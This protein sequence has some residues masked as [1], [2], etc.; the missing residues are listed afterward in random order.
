MTPHQF[1][2]PLFSSGDGPRTPPPLNDSIGQQQ[3]ADCTCLG[4]LTFQCSGRTKANPFQ[5][6]RNSIASHDDDILVN[7]GTGHSTVIFL[8]VSNGCTIQ[9]N[10]GSAREGAG[11][12][13]GCRRGEKQEAKMTGDHKQCDVFILRNSCI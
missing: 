9:G 6:V 8:M 13:G 7:S 2:S 12:I 4:R 10:S 5:S 3:W 1:L 11:N